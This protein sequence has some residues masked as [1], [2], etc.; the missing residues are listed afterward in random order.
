MLGSDARRRLK[1]HPT[2][3][4]TAL[5]EDALLDSSGSTLIAAQATGRVCRGVEL[6]PLYVDVIRSCRRL[7]CSAGER[8]AGARVRSPVVWIAGWRETKTLKPIDNVSLGETTGHRAVTTVNAKVASKVRSRHSDGGGL[9]FRV[10]GD[11]KAAELRARVLNGI[12]P[13]AEKHGAKGVIAKAGV[14]TFGEMALSHVETHEAGWRSPKHRQ[15]WR[16][17]LTQFCQPIWSMPVDQVTTTNVLEVLKPIWTTKSVTAGRL[18]GRIEVIIDAARVLGHIDAD[19]ANCARW[20]GHLQRLLPKPAKLTRGHHAAMPYAELPAFMAR[21]A[22]TPGVAA[23][24]LQF[25][26][27]TATRTSETLNMTFDEVS[28]ETATWTVPKER[29][30]MQRENQVPLSAAAAAILRAQKAEPGKNPHVFPGRPTKPL[31]SMALNMLL[32][33]MKVPVTIHGFRATFRMWAAEQ[34]I[35]FELAEQALAHA[36]GNQIVVAYQRSNLLEQ[37]RPVMESWGRYVTGADASNVIP[38]RRA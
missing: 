19:R 25:L 22:E 27:L 15:Q 34:G 4:P 11:H 13:F 8:P 35:A 33:R 24:A 29:M 37:R 23:L 5:P 2:V 38:I 21:L 3:K 6:D 10:L 1:D 14:P 17:T 7:A 20:K 31:S 16:Q 12:D 9:F 32:R 36:A 18:R 28:F 30:K 26:I